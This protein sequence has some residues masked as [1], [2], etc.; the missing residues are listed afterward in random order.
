MRDPIAAD[1]VP[2]RRH[3]RVLADQLTEALCA[4][5]PVQGAL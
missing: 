2:Q 3:D 5:A 4:E 1:R